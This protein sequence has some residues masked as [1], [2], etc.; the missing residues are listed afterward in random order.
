[1]K[2]EK[3]VRSAELKRAILEKAKSLIVPVILL[4]IILVGILVVLNYK[5]D[6]EE[7]P[8]IRVNGFD[9]ITEDIVLENDK[10]VPRP[11]SFPFR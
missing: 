10:L 5:N 11:L 3:S 9:G 1:M 8:V 7:E 6:E 2:K 4:I